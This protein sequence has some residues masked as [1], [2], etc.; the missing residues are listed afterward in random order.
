MTG[1]GSLELY[2]VTLLT[3]YQCLSVHDLPQHKFFSGI[4][5]IAD[6]L[7]PEP[8]VVDFK[9]FR[10]FLRRRKVYVLV[11]VGRLDDAEKLCQELL[12]E[13]MNSDYAL[14]E[15]AYIQQLKQKQLEPKK[16]E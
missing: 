9:L 3:K 4:A 12:K 11:E 1:Q 10:D 13:P 16:A 7:H 5:D 6:L 8:P 15:L 2:P 14:G